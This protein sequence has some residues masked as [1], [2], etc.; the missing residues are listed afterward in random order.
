MPR[1][2]RD[3]FTFFFRAESLLPFVDDVDDESDE[4]D[5]S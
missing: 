1:F 5:Y 3:S 4:S 2:G